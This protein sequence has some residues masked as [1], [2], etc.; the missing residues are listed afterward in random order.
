MKIYCVITERD[1][2]TERIPGKVT[3]EIVR[4][5][6]RY[7]AEHIV[8]VWEEIQ[9]LFDDPEVTV[10]GV[11]EEQ[12]QITVLAPRSASTEANDVLSIVIDVDDVTKRTANFLK[13]N[14]IKTIGE[15]TKLSR[16]DI[17]RTPNMGKRSIGEI[18]DILAA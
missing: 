10:I 6:Q 11:Y 7:A 1:G 18:I 9:Y 3:T 4:V 15:L 8:Q 5:Q 14:N 16:N 2:K 13:N 12:P 17:Y